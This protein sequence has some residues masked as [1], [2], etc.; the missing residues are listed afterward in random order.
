[1]GLVAATFAVGPYSSVT[2]E[3]WYR[4]GSISFLCVGA[5]L[6]AAALLLIARRFPIVII[7]SI[8]WMFAALLAFLDYMFMSGGGV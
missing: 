8:V 7:A 6:P 5:I 1:M 4:Y 3:N 2:Q